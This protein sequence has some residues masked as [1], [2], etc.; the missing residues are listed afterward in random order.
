M[1]LRTIMAMTARNQFIVILLNIMVYMNIYEYKKKLTLLFK[2]RAGIQV[3]GCFDT[4]VALRRVE[5]LDLLQRLVKPVDV[6]KSEFN[7]RRDKATATSLLQRR[8]KEQIL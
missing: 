1:N 3:S 6:E 7:P 8:M 5:A 2:G 4:A